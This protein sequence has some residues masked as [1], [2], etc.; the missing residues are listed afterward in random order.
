MAA[1]A[2]A[3]AASADAARTDGA[4]TSSAA[5]PALS[6]PALLSHIFKFAVCDLPSDLSNV[7]ESS[8]HASYKS[9]FAFRAIKDV[10]LVYVSTAWEDTAVNFCPWMWERITAASY[11]IDKAPPLEGTP[12]PSLEQWS[13]HCF[14]HA[15]CQVWS[16]LAYT[17]S[18]F[19]LLSC[20]VH[21]GLRRLSHPSRVA[22]KTK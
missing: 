20:G 10:K 14:N 16:R 18:L 12:Q 1:T 11:G 3:A 6:K 7:L 17:P 4:A 22:S 15:V 19:F 5:H 2:A 9:I 8:A 21:R 13:Q